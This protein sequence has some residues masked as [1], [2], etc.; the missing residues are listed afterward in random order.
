MQPRKLP[1]I[2][3]VTKEAPSA[4]SVGVSKVSSS[5]GRE[6][7]R[8]L[9]SRAC[10]A[11]WSRVCFSSGVRR[12]PMASSY[13]SLRKESSGD[14]FFMLNPT[15]LSPATK[16]RIDWGHGLH[17]FGGKLDG[18]TVE[19]APKPLSN[20]YQNRAPL[21]NGKR[22]I[23]KK[24]GFC[25]LRSQKPCFFGFLILKGQIRW[26]IFIHRLH[27]LLRKRKVGRDG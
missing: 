26:P 25:E 3:K 5:S 27:R 16:H 7:P 12:S 9:V 6:W 23:I 19:P 1:F 15:P 21:H 10:R 14:I 24:Q 4:R 8:T 17:F 2:V 20:K 18:L 22:E 11:N 13:N